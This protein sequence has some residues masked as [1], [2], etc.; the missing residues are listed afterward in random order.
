MEMLAGTAVTYGSVVQLLHLQSK[1]YVGIQSRT[2][3]DVEKHC[4]AVNLRSKGRPT[5][6]WKVMPRFKY[7]REG[8]KVVMGDMLLL[9]SVK[10][11]QVRCRCP[12]V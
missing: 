3:A 1:R 10:G 12:F 7:R 4:T 5:C 8:E 6:Y 9:V 2:L 11:D